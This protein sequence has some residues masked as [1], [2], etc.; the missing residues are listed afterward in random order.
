MTF[1]TAAVLLLSFCA[2]ILGIMAVPASA[3]I[4][5]K[6]TKADEEA[7]YKLE[8]QFYLT[9]IVVYV[10]LGARLTIVP[11]YFWTMQS[12]VPMIPGA[13]CMWGVF[14]A[15]PLAW[16]DLTL[17]L[18]FPVFYGGWLVLTRIN[19]VCKRN[20]LMTRL[21]GLFLIITPILIVDSILDIWIFMNLEPVQVSCCTSA[22]DVTPTPLPTAILGM[23]G[24]MFLLLVFIII[25]S[26]YATTMFA[27][28]RYEKMEWIP[29]IVSIILIPITILSITEVFTPWILHLPFHRCP[30]CLFQHVPVTVLFVTLF[31]LSLACPW[32]TLLSRK[33]GS[34]DE[35]S[36]TIEHNIR[37]T[38]WTI[39]GIAAV[40][41]VTVILTSLVVTFA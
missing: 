2:V 14:N 37:N 4:F 20:Q 28:L 11:L 27:S 29:R 10:I 35:E 34:V 33:V 18:L 7:K 39:G 23:G 24:Q 3:R 31:W 22:I 41:G 25:V 8:K 16:S 15:A 12:L 17:K 9:L 32:W 5:R 30:F 1:G 6:W 21:T 13:M 26:I 38:L 40:I 19:S 36:A